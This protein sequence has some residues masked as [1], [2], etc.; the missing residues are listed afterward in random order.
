MVLYLQIYSYLLFNI[1]STAMHLT[2]WGLLM[3]A[4]VYIS[5]GSRLSDV[6][7]GYVAQD[8][9][10]SEPLINKIEVRGICVY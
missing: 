6:V 3:L 9:P 7:N 8:V 5:A 2:I 1:T 4:S 10:E